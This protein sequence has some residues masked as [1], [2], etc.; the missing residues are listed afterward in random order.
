[1]THCSSSP[2]A[3]QL[4][5]RAVHLDLKGVPPTFERLMD[6]LAIF[7]AAHYNAIL[8]EW[9]DMFPWQFDP[10]MRN[11]TAYSPAQVRE[12]T[13]RANELSIQL[14]PLVQ[15]FGHAETLLSLPEYAG[16][17]EK[18]WICSDF[19]P[20][21]QEGRRLITLMIDEVLSLMPHTQY[22]H[23]GCDEVWTLGFQ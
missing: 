12:F 3:S 14:I 17:R 18:P 20:L 6:L 2:S 10:R 11:T 8:V 23:L 1:M 5:L 9:E 21:S 7:K 15:S 19:N 4:D 13:A 22:F 16:L